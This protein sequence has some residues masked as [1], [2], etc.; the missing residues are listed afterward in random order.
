MP[1]TKRAVSVDFLG[2]REEGA[3]KTEAT[4]KA[5]QRIED[6]FRRE[7][8]AELI[9]LAPFVIALSRDVYSDWGYS[10]ANTEECAPLTPVRRWSRSS[11]YATKQLAREAALYNCAQ[12]SWDPA[13]GFTA[14]PFV[15]G[16]ERRR[17]FRSWAAWQTAFRQLNAE[18]LD[19][20]DTRHW[21]KVEAR[22]QELLRQEEFDRK[23]EEARLP[24][25]H[26]ALLAS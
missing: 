14:P 8:E 23:A 22:K 4:A 17:E 21:D 19:A 6:F 25:N 16:E 7:N 18:G 5:R 10:W 12:L 2:V 9:V 15:E 24:D 11:F 13:H 3:T 1:R 20:G 26:P